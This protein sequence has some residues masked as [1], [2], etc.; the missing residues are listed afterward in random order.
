MSEKIKPLK[1]NY[2]V[3]YILRVYVLRAL[4]LHRNEGGVSVESAPTLHRNEG[5][6]T[7]GM[8]QG[9]VGIKNWRSAPNDVAG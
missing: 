3:V 7:E 4:R 1:I 2:T 9:K 6:G 5:G 8:R